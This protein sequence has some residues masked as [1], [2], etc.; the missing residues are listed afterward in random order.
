MSNYVIWFNEKEEGPYDF[1]MLV[2]FLSLGTITPD[3]PV[4]G[5]FDK[6]WSTFAA[7]NKSATAESYRRRSYFRE[8]I[9][10]DTG[11]PG[12][13][14]AL[15]L[16]MGC[17]AAIAIISWI[18]WENMSSTDTDPN[19]M[20]TRAGFFWCA[21]FSTLSLPATFI[22]GFVLQAVLDIADA[23]LKRPPEHN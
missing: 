17:A 19:E 9:R 4:R 5:V 10:G 18:I 12:L 8:H 20:A 22:A 21:L 23:N 1:P 13:R 2:R 11:Y 6:T 7:I 16:W 3:T 15:K 14:V